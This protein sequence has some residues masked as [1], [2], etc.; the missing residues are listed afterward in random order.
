MARYNPKQVSGGN[1]TIMVNSINENFTKI[2]ES[3]Q[4]LLS[5]V[6]GEEPNTIETDIDVNSHD[7]KNI[8]DTYTKRLFINGKDVTLDYTVESD[9]YL[10]VQ[11]QKLEIEAMVDGIEGLAQDEIDAFSD[12]ATL[13]AEAAVS[14]INDAKDAAIQA[15]EDAAAGAGG[16]PNMQQITG[17]VQFPKDSTVDIFYNDGAT[18]VN[19]VLGFSDLGGYRVGTYMQLGDGKITFEGAHGGVNIVCLGNLE[20]SGKGA[21]VTVLRRS[22]NEFVVF[23]AV[24]Q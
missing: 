19:V 1:T 13:V 10:W 6:G 20:T 14:D 21:V 24:S 8:N 12:A 16:I 11:E 23:G 5:R 3:M 17:E 15:I 7:L 4:D 2:A 18:D 9:F 22:A